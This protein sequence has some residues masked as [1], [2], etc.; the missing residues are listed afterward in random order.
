MLHSLNKVEEE[1]ESNYIKWDSVEAQN[2]TSIGFYFGYYY[3]IIPS[4]GEAGAIRAKNWKAI[5]GQYPPVSKDASFQLLDSNG[6]ATTAILQFDVLTDMEIHFLAEPEHR[7]N[8]GAWSNIPNNN[9][10][11]HALMT[12]AFRFV[13][14][15]I[16]PINSDPPSLKNGIHVKNIPYSNYSKNY[17][18]K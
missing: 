5:Y 8:G 4:Y 14:D 17:K 11:D 18:G 2:S 16:G 13:S 9:D 3:F 6:Q 1:E 12:L 10:W 7:Y 15:F